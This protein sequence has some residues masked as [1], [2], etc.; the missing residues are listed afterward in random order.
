M[1]DAQS[2]NARLRALSAMF[3][4]VAIVAGGVVWSG[5]GSNSDTSSESTA[6]A[7][8]EVEEGVK[9]AEEGVEEG[10]EQAQ[11]GLE[12]AK[13]QAEGSKG[14]AKKSIEEGTKQAEKGIEEAKQQAEKYLP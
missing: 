13:K 3:A 6:T 10:T 14:A 2:G 4:L 8:Q 12:E 11:K 1:K 9:K 7:K 5:C